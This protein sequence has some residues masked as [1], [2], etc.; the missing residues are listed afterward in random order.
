M[1]Q[2]N[3]AGH[4]Q[5][6]RVERALIS[7]GRV[8]AT[9]G[10]GLEEIGVSIERSGGIEV[11]NT[12]S[13]TVPNIWAAGDATMD[14]ALV[15]VAELEGR[16]AVERMFGL[17]PAPIRY[18]ALSAIMFLMPEVASVGLNELQAQKK[19]VPYRVS[20]LHNSLN[21]RNIAMRSTD[22]FIKL[23][24]SRGAPARVLGLRVVGPMASSTIQGIAFLIEQR[25]TLEDIDFCVHPHPAITEGV[26]EC[27]RILLGRSIHKADVFSDLLRA[28]EG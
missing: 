10:L 18:E 25:A 11:R 3:A 24:A 5:K 1:R 26:Q 6:I 14:L 9:R 7:V 13:T 22:G 2:A 12:Q 17:D 27:A 28:G 16:H 21:A 15:N 8:P 4:R 23:L 19:Q 20:V